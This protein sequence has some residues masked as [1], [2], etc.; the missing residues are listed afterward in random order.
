VPP[1]VQPE[2]EPVES[3]DGL[4]SEMKYEVYLAFSG[5]AGNNIG[6]LMATYNAPNPN[7]LAKRAIALLLSAKGKDILLRDRTTGD[8]RAVQV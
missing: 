3:L 2:P 5:A 7:D 8:T 6:E 4:T 1:R